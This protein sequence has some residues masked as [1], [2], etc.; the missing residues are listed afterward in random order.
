VFDLN[1][2]LVAERYLR[3]DE[4]LENVLKCRRRDRKLTVEDLRSVARGEWSLQKIITKIYNEEDP[5][6]VA[7]Q[8]YKLQALRVSFRKN[9]LE[10]LI[11]LH[12]RYQLILCSDTT[13]I[14]RIVVKNLNLHNY[15]KSV[16]FSCDVGYL[17]SERKF[18]IQMLSHYPKL[19]TRELLVVGDNPRA[20][21]FHPNSLG[22]H[23]IQIE[24]PLQQSFDYREAATN[25]NEE[26]P[27][28]Y[29]KELGELIP[30]LTC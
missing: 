17:K 7:N 30:L 27:E 26:K 24:N 4:M 29:I 12:K 11:E 19:K 6:Q 21:T 28:Y 13:G 5:V 14:A 2:T 25:S 1:G 15:F 3:P 16:F 22:M 23:T 20:D 9:A 8:Y 18:W 10:V